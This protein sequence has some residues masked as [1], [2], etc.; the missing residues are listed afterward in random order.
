M[1]MPVKKLNDLLK[2]KTDIEE[3]R[4]KIIAENKK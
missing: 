3:Q 2:W 1:A 4:S